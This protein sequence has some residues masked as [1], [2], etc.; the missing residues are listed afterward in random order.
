MWQ[1]LRIKRVSKIHLFILNKNKWRQ[2]KTCL[3]S[4]AAETLSGYIRFPHKSDHAFL[5]T[6]ARPH[7]LGAQSASFLLRDVIKWKKPACC[8]MC[9]FNYKM[10]R[11]LCSICANVIQIHYF[12]IQTIPRWLGCPL[13]FYSATHPLWLRW[14]LIIERNAAYDESFTN[15]LW[16]IPA[17]GKGWEWY[18]CV[19][20]VSPD[21]SRVNAI[22]MYH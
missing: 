16:L 4:H 13:F 12:T 21:C 15:M 19:G 17:D 10:C 2:E 22:V 14:T 5:C 1:C 11:S 8:C 18:N 3:L 20:V 7:A 9:P 6:V